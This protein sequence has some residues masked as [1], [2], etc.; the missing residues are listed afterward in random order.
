M[1]WPLWALLLM[2]QNGAHTLCS[3]ARNG[4]NLWYNGVASAFS[5]GIW[6]ASNFILVDSIVQ[7]LRAAD[8]AKALL[9]GIFYTVFTLT[10]SVGMHY[11]AMHYIE[12]PRAP[13]EPTT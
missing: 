2:A 7:V 3:R 1:K 8:W 9:I 4:R 13:K 5:N 10:G 11:I 6:F 12:A